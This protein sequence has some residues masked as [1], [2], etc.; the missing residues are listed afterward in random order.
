MSLADE[1]QAA[2]LEALRARNRSGAAACA[3]ARAHEAIL[4]ECTALELTA[5]SC[6]RLQQEAAVANAAEAQAASAAQ[7]MGEKLAEAQAKV[8][9]LEHSLQQS[10]AREAAV[11]RENETL[12]ARLTEQLQ[13]RAMAMDTEV[14]Q[15]ERKLEAEAAAAAEMDKAA[16]T[17]SGGTDDLAA[18]AGG[19]AEEAPGPGG[20]APRGGGPRRAGGSQGGSEPARAPVPVD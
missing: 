16:P 20:R 4:A 15:F 13:M 8:A 11:R 10:V 17:T 5:R 12:L 1:P 19:D 2:V 14:E 3:L 18:A 9:E 7:Q 6:E